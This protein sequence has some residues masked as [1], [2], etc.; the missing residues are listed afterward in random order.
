MEIK[1]FTTVKKAAMKVVDIAKNLTADD[2]VVMG[3]CALGSLAV[4]SIF[5]TAL[6]SLII[7]AVAGL[8]I[9]NKLTI[10]GI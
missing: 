2:W 7:G 3:Y 1:I 10:K 8:M 5:G 4:V 9:Q 6:G